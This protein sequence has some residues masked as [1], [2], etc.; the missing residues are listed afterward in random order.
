MGATR[1]QA[2]MKKMGNSSSNKFLCTGKKTGST[3]WGAKEQ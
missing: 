3:K 2:K 1:A